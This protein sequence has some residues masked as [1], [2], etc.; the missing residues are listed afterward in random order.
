LSEHFNVKKLQAGAVRK[1][2]LPL[3]RVGVVDEKVTTWTALPR[4][5]PSVGHA[6]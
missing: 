5:V 6:G 1:P 3:V 2:E 4:I